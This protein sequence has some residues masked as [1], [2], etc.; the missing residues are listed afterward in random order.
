M[1]RKLRVRVTLTLISGGICRHSLHVETP[2]SC[3]CSTG[4]VQRNIYS[5]H[6][7]YHRDC[8]KLKVLQSDRKRSVLSA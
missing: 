4:N 2:I 3:E 6:S 8:S 5:Q 7:S 1:A